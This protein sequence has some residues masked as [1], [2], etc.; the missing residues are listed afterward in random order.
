MKKI[1]AM[2]MTVAIFGSLS[3]ATEYSGLAFSDLKRTMK[4]ADDY[5]VTVITNE[6]FS[7]ENCLWYNRP[8][9]KKDKKSFTAVDGSPFGDVVTV[10]CGN[11]TFTVAITKNRKFVRSEK[12]TLMSIK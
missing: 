12:G 6:P 1:W 10:Y 7:V 9:D 11:T 4:F 8:F 2:A 5:G 3:H